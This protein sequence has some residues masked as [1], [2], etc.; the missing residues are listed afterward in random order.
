MFVTVVGVQAGCFLLRLD[1]LT[2]EQDDGFLVSSFELLESSLQ[3]SFEV[4]IR[5]FGSDVVEVEFFLSFLVVVGD[6]ALLKAIDVFFDGVGEIACGCEAF[7]LAG[8]G[9]IVAEMTLDER[10]LAERG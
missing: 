3:V 8:D 10:C 9:I 1:S 7:H 6:D 4:P 5:A 2:D